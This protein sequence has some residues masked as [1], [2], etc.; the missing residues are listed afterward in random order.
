MKKQL[1]AI[2]AMT[3]LAFGAQAAT[4][5]WDDGTVTV[6][7]ASGGGTG[8]WTVGASGWED[9]TSAQNWADGN[10][11]VLGGTAG[12]LTLG[13]NISVGNVTLGVNGYTVDSA[14][15][16]MAITGVMSGAYTFTYGGAGA[17]TISGTNTN[18][19]NLTIDAA[20]VT[21]NSGATLFCSGAGWAGRT[22]TL[23][24]G[25]MLV[26]DNYANGAGSLWGECGDSA[27]NVI[28]GTGGGTFKML[29]TTMNSTVN[30]GFTVNSG[31]T[32]H[33]FVPTGTSATWSKDATDYSTSRDFYVNG[34]TLDF[35]G[36]G[37][38]TTSRGIRGSGNVT[39]SDG[40]TLTLSW[41][42]TF[43]GALTVNGGTLVASATTSG[44]SSGTGNGSATNVITVN[45]GATLKYTVSRGA[46]YHGA[47]V[48]INGGTITFDNSDMSFA[49]GKTVTFDTA[50]G[51]INGTGQWRM[52]DASP[53]VTV[54][55]AAS[56]SLI[57]V[58][59]LTLTTTTG[60]RATFDVADG[61][62]ANDLT[63][64]SNIGEHV[65]GETLTKTGGGTLTLSGNNSYT[66]ATAVN[67]GT[68]RLDGSVTSAVTVASGAKLQGV[69]TITKTGTALTVNGT[70]APGNSIGQLTVNGDV[71]LAG[72]SDFEIDPDID[73]SDLLLVQGTNGALT[74]GGTLN[75]SI[76]TGST[77][78]FAMG[79]TFDLFNFASQSGTFGTVNLPDISG[80]GY[81]WDQSALYTA[82]TI[83]VIPE[84]ATVGL[85]GLVGAM[86]LL[87]RR[88]KIKN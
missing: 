49:S 36:G 15:N 4:Y 60:S 5:Y 85:L 77:G 52:R 31:V 80:Q 68:L 61:S 84:P 76:L 55:A 16:T 33:F 23:Q 75:V 12:T 24:N 67:N 34:G 50:A 58:G 41:V 13:G 27:S 39:K 6:N 83:T 17:F 51:T 88:M 82:G 11:A 3:A 63:I 66:G 26:A 8:A 40:G 9:G 56:G 28:F 78:I 37:N 35:N 48:F 71:T 19:G 29:G 10:A 1:V 20:T 72:A 47:N 42:N 81:S 32:G 7:G 70:L 59:T 22:V 57:S 18:S 65:A 74:Y 53:K 46:G 38:F 86:A 54:T 69:G 44:N 64:S 43:S 62:A 30:K 79:D 25:G 73:G 45:N 21:V 87:R 2:L 14:G